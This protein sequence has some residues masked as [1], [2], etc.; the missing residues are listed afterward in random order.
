VNP[1]FETPEEIS[2]LNPQPSTL[3]ARGDEREA[4]GYRAVTNG[5]ECERRPLPEEMNEKLRPTGLD[6]HRLTVAPDEAFGAIF[7]YFQ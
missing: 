1:E 6:R 2:T 7:R 5:Y 4:A 3:N